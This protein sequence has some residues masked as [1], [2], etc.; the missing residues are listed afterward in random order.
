MMSLLNT[1]WPLQ[2]FGTTSDFAAESVGLDSVET[3]IVVGVV[4]SR[5]VLELLRQTLPLDESSL[6]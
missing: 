5:R 3:E 6:N 1:G 2:N 4:R